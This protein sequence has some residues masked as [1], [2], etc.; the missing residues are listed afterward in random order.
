[1]SDLLAS[2]NQSRTEKINQK[3]QADEFESMTILKM[4]QME[5]ER[6]I[7]EIRREEEEG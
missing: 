1:M 6:L 4:R 2:H 3:K 5:R 7:E